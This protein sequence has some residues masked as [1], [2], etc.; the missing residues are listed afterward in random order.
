MRFG[1]N[2]EQRLFQASVRS[3]LERECPPERVRALWE[4]ETGRSPDLWAKLAEVGLTG[5]LVPERY[6]GLGMD[7]I[8]L[9]L[10]LEEA[11]RVALAEPLLE[12][13]VGS[14][15]LRDGAAEE[16]AASWLPR[17]AAGEAI[18]AIGHPIDPC[19]ADAHVADLL[20][21]PRAGELHA[22][23][24]NAVRL[25]RQPC[26]D[27]ARRLFRVAWEPSQESCLA[28]G[29]GAQ[30]LLDAAFD[31]AALAVAAEQL[32]IAERLVE[33]AV[34][35]AKQREQFGKPIGS[36]QAIKHMLASVQVRIE[37]ARPVV[38]RAAFSVARGAPAR[39]TH[40][41]HAKAAASEAAVLAA[42]TAL[43]VHGAIGYTWEVDLHLWM[44]RA[45]A[46][47]ATWG[48]S[49]WHRARVGSAVL[50]GNVPAPA[51][52][53][54]TPRETAREGGER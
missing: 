29:D 22:L 5:L 51:F 25:E 8:D 24:R 2:E 23:A 50:G 6:G 18:L 48:G 47:E 38:Y 15:L 33:L 30:G 37:F 26:L 52:G 28:K 1:F 34:E 10:P 19:V 36:F 27:G 7:E 41:S 39:S 32:G 13:A 14:A 53:F 40:A 11:G 4:H 54:A 12:N 21:L 49:A 16:L 17:V 9:V 3:L 44:K 46:L 45:W 35:Y 42:K 20:I 31:R 43:Q